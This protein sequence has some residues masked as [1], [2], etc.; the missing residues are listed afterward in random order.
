M[1]YDLLKG[2]CEKIFNFFA[3]KVVKKAKFTTFRLCG[4]TCS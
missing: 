1:N 3:K 4:P 2:F